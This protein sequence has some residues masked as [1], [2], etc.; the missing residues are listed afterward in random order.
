MPL[1]NL[2]I[3]IGLHKTG[4][5]WLQETLFSSDSK[6]FIPLSPDGDPKYFGILFIWAHRRNLLSP[7]EA[8]E[9]E[10]R[11][12][13]LE[14]LDN[15]E[16]GEKIP[17]IS[18]ERL[19]GHPDSGRF[20]CK[21]IADR[22]KT[23]F[24]D[25]KILCVIREQRDMILSTYF[26]YLKMGGIDSLRK[27]I[28][29]R[30]DAR[31]PGFELSNYYYLDLVSYYFKLFSKKNVLV[32]PYEMFK[33]DLDLFLTHLGNFT[34]TDLMGWEQ[35]GKEII[36]KRSNDFAL[37]RFPFLNLF[38]QKSSINAYSPLYIRGGEKLIPY[39]NWFLGPF[40]KNHLT[41]LPKSLD[42]FVGDKF[43]K[44]NQE[45][46]KLIGIDLSRYGYF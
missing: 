40:V 21:T 20:D 39:A 13:L 46:S 24:P 22:I 44:T 43:V 29:R 2:L 4:T 28:S 14:I 31:R 19:S 36:N 41:T 1:N 38:F 9:K 18:H 30:N 32:L 11:K 10:I 6:N 15:L 37:S 5:T 17:V 3:H 34:K 7:F 25:A 23:N 42:S 8:N 27:Y 26:Q 12:E 16:I 35:M 33:E 45:L